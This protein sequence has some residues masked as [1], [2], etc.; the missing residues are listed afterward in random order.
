MFYIS[1]QRW[2]VNTIFIYCLPTGYFR[3]SGLDLLRQVSVEHF[4]QTR[5]AIAIYFG[6]LENC[7]KYIQIE[8]GASIREEFCLGKIILTFYELPVV[9]VGQQELNE[10]SAPSSGIKSEL[11]WQSYCCEVS[12]PV[13]VS[14][15][16]AGVTR[17]WARCPSPPRHS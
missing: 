15:S 16:P 3:G 14:T 13:G 9:I 1:L 17:S 7:F 5:L 8:L 11:P 6:Q 12:P 4:A 10:F 2:K